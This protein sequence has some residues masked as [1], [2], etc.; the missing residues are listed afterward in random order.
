M[1]TYGPFHCARPTN[2]ATTAIVKITTNFP[3]FVMIVNIS[4]NETNA[5]KAEIPKPINAFYILFS[6]GRHSKNLDIGPVGAATTSGSD[7][8]K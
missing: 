3:G 4:N 2:N 5:N 7:F 8:L 1:Y 6:S